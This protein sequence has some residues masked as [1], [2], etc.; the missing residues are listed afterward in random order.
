MVTPI[1]IALGIIFIIIVLMIIVGFFYLNRVVPPTALV[2]GF[3]LT[4]KTSNGLYLSIEN[5]DA[6]SGQGVPNIMPIMVV[7]GLPNGQPPEPTEGWQ[8]LR[9]TNQPK[10][11]I[12]TFFNPSNSGYIKYV[13]D[14]NGNIVGNIINV[15]QITPPPDPVDGNPASFLGWF[16]L[17]QNAINNTTLF[18]SLYPGP[19]RGQNQYLIPGVL[20]QIPNDPNITPATI[21]IPSNGNNEWI[22]G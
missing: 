1:T 22:V 11:N 12:V 4:I 6:A 3:G 14:A 18:R 13:V 2:T 10:S 16:A 21:G 7:K 20:G 19:I 15:A 9:P 17:E 8:L 5:I